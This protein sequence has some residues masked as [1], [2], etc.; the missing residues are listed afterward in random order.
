MII[1]NDG[2]LLTMISGEDLMNTIGNSKKETTSIQYRVI[3][4]QH[5]LCSYTLRFVGKSY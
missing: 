3:F 1:V 4:R 2:V 5:K